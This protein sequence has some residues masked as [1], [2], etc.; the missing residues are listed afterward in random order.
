MKLILLLVAALLITGSTAEAQHGTAPS[1]YYPDTFQGDTWTGL[2]ASKNDQTGEITLQYSHGDK[3]ETFVG[4]IEKGYLVLPRG[5]AERPLRPTD[6]PVGMKITVY[7]LSDTVKIE[8]KKVK[9]YTIFT[10]KEVPNNRQRSVS[11]RAFYN[12]PANH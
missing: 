12:P 5:G 10:I 6:L 7:Y 9:V 11:F 4:I 8:G 2:I 1:G 3:T